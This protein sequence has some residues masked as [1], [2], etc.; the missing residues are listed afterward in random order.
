MQI[1]F[2]KPKTAI[3]AFF[4]GVGTITVFALIAFIATSTMDR[5]VPIDLL[6]IGSAIAIFGVL[7]IPAYVHEEQFKQQPERYM[8]SPGYRLFLFSFA[9]F[10]ILSASYF[11]GSIVGSVLDRGYIQDFDGSTT[12]VAMTTIAGLSLLSGLWTM[13]RIRKAASRT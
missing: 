3:E 2:Q 12:A 8:A 13:R 4:M 9:S 11:L 7:S 10:G 5:G 6:K 1:R